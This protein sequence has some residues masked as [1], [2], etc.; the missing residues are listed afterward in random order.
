MMKIDIRKLFL[1]IFLIALLFNGFVAELIMWLCLVAMMMIT[2]YDL[3]KQIGSKGYKIAIF[4]CVFYIILYIVQILIGKHDIIHTI[5]LYGLTKNICAPALMLL[6]FGT[7][8]KDR[9]PIKFVMLMLTIFNLL[10]ISAILNPCYDDVISYQM[11]SLNGGSGISVVLLPAS[12]YYLKHSYKNNPLPQMNI[13]V[14]FIFTTLL[15][16]ALSD[17]TTSQLLLLFEILV[18][19]TLR[20]RMNKK[21]LMR[22]SLVILIGTAIISLLIASGGL[23]LN[24]DR[25][26]TR[27]GIWTRAYNYFREQE[28]FYVMFGAGDDIVQMIT[29]SLEAHNVFI[30]I[31]L[32][33]GVAGLCFFIYFFYKVSKRILAFQTENMRYI[34]ACIVSYATICSLHP[35]YTGLTTFQSVSSISIMFLIFNDENRLNKLIIRG[36]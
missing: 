18:Y 17:S 24:P 26:K 12:I 20:I 13:S 4:F 14:L 30:E 2:R 36:T 8:C 9:F 19:I 7:I 27:V 35:F 32:I 22:V 28:T 25:L 31:L 6:S 3:K 11:G 15:F 10:Y 1:V 23:A 16:I 5:R 34:V 29:K 33:Y 21:T